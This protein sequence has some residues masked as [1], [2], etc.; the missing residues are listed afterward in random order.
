MAV[1][2]PI[3]KLA[4]TTNGLYYCAF[5]N[6]FM[7]ETMKDFDSNDII[8]HPVHNVAKGCINGAITVLGTAIVNDFF[9][10]SRLRPLLSGLL[11]GSSIVYTGRELMPSTS[12]QNVNKPD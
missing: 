6:G 8:E 7:H 2:G 11:V 5:G 1:F 3:Y 9:L 10:P 12:T 4:S